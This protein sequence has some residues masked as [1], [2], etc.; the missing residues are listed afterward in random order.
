[1]LKLPIWITVIGFVGGI[2]MFVRMGSKD[3]QSGG[4]IYG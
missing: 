2:I 1:M 3:N 4:S